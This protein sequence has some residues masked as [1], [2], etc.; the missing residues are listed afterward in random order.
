MS[1]FVYD[2]YGNRY[3]QPDKPNK[4]R[5]SPDFDCPKAPPALLNQSMDAIRHGVALFTCQEMWIELHDPR[6]CVQRGEWRPIFWAPGAQIE[7]FRFKFNE[8][9]YIATQRWS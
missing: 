9:H 4:R 3:M 6:V 7:P 2:P 8:I 5:Y 1:D